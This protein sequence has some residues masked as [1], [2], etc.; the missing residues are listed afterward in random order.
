MKKKKDWKKMLAGFSFLEAA[1][2]SISPRYAR[3]SKHEEET[4]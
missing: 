3:R 1:P 2:R 4:Y